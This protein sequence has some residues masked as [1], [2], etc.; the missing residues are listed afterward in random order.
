MVGQHMFII[1]QVLGHAAIFM[2][3]GKEEEAVLVGIQ[4][5]NLPSTPQNGLSMCVLGFNDCRSSI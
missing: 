1:E 3:M 5:K 4:M 2:G